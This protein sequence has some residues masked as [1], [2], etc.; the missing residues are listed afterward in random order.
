M[1]MIQLNVPMKRLIIYPVF[2]LIFSLHT[3]YAT[4]IQ[5]VQTGNWNT[6]ATWSAGVP[7]NNDDVI[8]NTN[9]IVTIDNPML[10]S[11]CKS[12]TVNGK[13]IYNN[14]INFA[15]GS[16]NDRTSAFI[17]NGIFEYSVGYSF[18]VYGYMKFSTGSTFQMTS[19]GMIIDGTL[20]AT[21]SVPA[22]QAHLDVTDIGTLTCFKS[23]ISIRNP[24]YDAL[25]PCI[26]GAKRF[27]NTIGFG[28]GN[29]PDSPNDFTISETNKPSFSYLE[30]NIAN[31]TSRFKA[32][33]IVIDS[34]VAILN[35]GIYNY[36]SAT[37]IKMKSDLNIGLGVSLTGNFE[38]N[39]TGQQNINTQFGSGATTATFNGDLIVNNP[40]EVKSKMNVTIV[41]GDLK[42]TQ[43][44]FDTEAKTLTLERTPVGTNSSKYIITDNFYHDIG[45]VL[46]KNLSVNTLF[47]IGTAHTYA[48]VWVNAASGNFKASV[49]LPQTAA[50]AGLG[51]ATVNLEWNVQRLFGPSMANITVQ[52]NTSD[53]TAG[54]TAL[55]GHCSLFHYT[56][57]VWEAVTPTGGANT[58]GTIHTKTAVGVEDFSPFAL[59]T[60]STLPVEISQFSGK[61]QGNR[62]Q[63][64]WTTASEKDNAGFEIEKN[65]EGSDFKSI[66]F[67]KSQGNTNA[68]TDYVFVDNDFTK[69]AYYRLKQTGIDGKETFSKIISIE[70]APKKDVMAV[71]P[72]PILRGSDLNIQLSDNA[73]SDDFTVEIYNA[74]GQ[75]VGEQRGIQPIKTDDWRTGVYFVKIVNTVNVVTF[76]VVKN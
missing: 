8:I 9:N 66:G 68:S 54:F 24:H 1:S 27:G 20:G 74:N 18:K 37:T 69:T 56:G 41:G 23:T 43:G 14:E 34:A 17:I 13:L 59:F 21:T 55:R 3:A 71:F 4:P 11:S 48:P 45:F 60:S 62:A 72:N 38:F 28:V 12:L 15:I 67:V 76:K 49:T 26:K 75:R 42:F 22:G 30:I 65:T 31:G 6:P 25:T 36:S 46:I 40:T 63:L 2:A 5:S 50:P 32:T 7:T 58:S 73:V 39:G 44:R 51:Y 53:E 29:T 70:N 47:P 35:G 33:D 10:S 61:K 64:S 19:G 52:W 16:F 57:T